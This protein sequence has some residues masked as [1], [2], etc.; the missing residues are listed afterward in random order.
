MPVAIVTGIIAALIATV[1]GLMLVGFFSLFLNRYL[2]W[3]V[4]SKPCPLQHPAVE[5]ELVAESPF[6]SDTSPLLEEGGF[7]F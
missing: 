7:V 3:V 2:P 4:N 5:I 1:P 6:Y